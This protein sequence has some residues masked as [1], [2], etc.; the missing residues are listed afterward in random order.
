MARLHRDTN[1]LILA[2]QR[3]TSEETKLRA[4]VA[5]VCDPGKPALSLWALHEAGVTDHRLQPAA[6]FFN[7]LLN[8]RASETEF[9]EVPRALAA[10]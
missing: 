10:V 7:R 4:D 1:F 2:L 5:G 6:S 8:A 3:G 9:H